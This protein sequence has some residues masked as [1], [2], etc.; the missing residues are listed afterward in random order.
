[1]KKS[2]NM[3]YENCAIRDGYIVE[4]LKDETIEHSIYSVFEQL[5]GEDGI[6]ISIKKCSKVGSTSGDD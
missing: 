3:T 4:C 2:I 1:M 6:T 5:E